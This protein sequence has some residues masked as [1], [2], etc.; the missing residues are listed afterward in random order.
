MTIS[1]RPR[2]SSS[3]PETGFGLVEVI[4]SLF[5][6]GLMALVILP[7]MVSTIRLS[8]SNIS[9][10]TATQLVTEQMDDARG[11][12]PTCAALRAWAAQTGGLVVTDP[13]GTILEAHRKVPATCPTAYP[14]TLS[15]EAW[16][17]VQGS[18]TRI[19][20]GETLVRLASAS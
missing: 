19:A 11:L 18:T 8:S 5:L 1:W 2:A 20:V 16:V 6:L 3:E 9:L 14:A 7:V 4:V 13:R 12:A 10:T 15:L 17:T